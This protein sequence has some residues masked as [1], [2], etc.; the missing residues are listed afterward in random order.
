[1]FGKPVFHNVPLG[2]EYWFREGCHILELSNTPV[3]AAVS[4]ARARVTPGQRTRW[5]RLVATTERYVILE[6]EG[7]VEIGNSPP[8][9]VTPGSVVII[10]PLCRQR[11]TNTGERDLIFLA[12]CSPRFMPENYQDGEADGVD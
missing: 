9:T 4:I 6:G 2:Q 5:H 7:S 11:I 8:Q 10:P 3:D 1:M 12:I